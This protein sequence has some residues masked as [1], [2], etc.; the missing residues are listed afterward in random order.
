MRPEGVSTHVEVFAPAILGNRVVC[1][2][3]KHN[4]N[5]SA[6]V[7][8]RSVNPFIKDAQIRVC[9]FRIYCRER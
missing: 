7:I 3:Y 2:R 8:F 6:C 9:N 1:V 4:S 5:V